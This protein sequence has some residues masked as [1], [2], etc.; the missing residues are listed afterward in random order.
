MAGI[1]AGR[2]QHFRLLV[3]ALFIILLVPLEL[4]LRVY[5]DA[6][7]G[8]AAQEIL[9]QANRLRALL[10]SE[11][12]TAAFL[13][14]G[15]ESY[16]VA[17]EGNIEQ[18]EIQRILA[19]VFE[20]GRHFRNIGVAPGNQIAWVFPLAGNEAA[21]GV[22][23][24]DIPQ[25]WPA[26]EQ[27]MTTRQGQL[28]G[29][30]ELVQG[31]NG[32]IY[33]APV[34]IDDVYWGLLSTVIDADSLLGL[35][36]SVSGE[37]AP[38][39]ALRNAGSD[40]QPGRVFYGQPDYFDA[41]LELLPVRVPGGAWQMAVQIP[42]NSLT[43]IGW[44]RVLGICL[45]LLL[46]V[47]LGLMLRLVWQRNLLGQLDIE[48]RAR[49]AD[50]RETNELL[51]SVLS[52]ARSFAIIASD[53]NGTI[54]VFNKG[55]ERMLGYTAEEMVGK[56]RPV[57]FLLTDELSERQVQ[58]EAELG[59]PLVG[60]EVLTLRARQGVE[61]MFSLH[62][63]HR[64]GH[65]IPVQGVVSAITDHNGEIHGYLGIAEDISERLRNEKLKNQFISTVSHELRTPLTAITGALGL[66][67]SGS[68]GRV[69]ESANAMVDIAYNNSKRLAQLVNDLLDMEKLM[70]GHMVLYPATHRVTDLVHTTVADLQS[71][72]AKHQVELVE[73]LLFDAHL[74]VD[75]LRFQQVLTNLLGNAIKFSPS[76]GQV[77]IA[78]TRSAGQIKITVLDQG[79]GIPASFQPHIFQRFAQA[80]VGDSR[81]VSGTGLGLAISKQLTE[82]MGGRIGFDAHL[83][84]GSCF[85]LE[86]TEHKKPDNGD[87]NV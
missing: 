86:F 42:P 53:N 46:S 21:I 66:V 54:T 17:R 76:G 19:L 39:I 48:V 55:A 25:Q 51:D 52:A 35:L 18:A 82:Q 8:Q 87:N 4:S 2:K 84:Q 43:H 61:E 80:E 3:I 85:W 72:A 38:L 50:L 31:G 32:L 69:P 24:A 67:R 81:Q 65:L 5:R 59:R 33:R 74:S 23:Y 30:L 78:V 44:L 37:G 60:D 73:T 71:V 7:T 58:L 26:I 75:A 83:R 68:A 63:K 16:I 79:P 27:A 41:P 9:E 1:E 29:P 12:S 57:T 13:A 77:Q 45:A 49:T 56:H 34:F 62:Y 36:G 11:V 15:V 20:R 10:E 70:A 47:L 6:S 64:D 14:T 22:N 28:A 40:S